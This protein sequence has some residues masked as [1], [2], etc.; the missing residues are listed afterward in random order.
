MRS[1][2]TY[3][4]G[5]STQEFT[6]FDTPIGRCGIVWGEHGIVGVFLPEPDDARTR[7]RL[8]RHFPDAVE[9]RPSA[10]LQTAIQQIT[11]L[12]SG[13]PQDLADV[14]LD[15]E[16]I[17]PFRQEV[18][19]IAR[20]IPPGETLTYGAIAE[21]LGDKLLARDVG[22]AM[23]KNPFPIVVPCHRVVAANGKLGGFSAPG[24][25]NTKLKMLAIEG[26]AVGGQP[27]L[28][29]APGLR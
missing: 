25:A 26:A 22:E 14:P 15:M 17:E 21:K 23:G 28:F 5:M 4:A 20:K 7:K 29:D 27:G 9:A 24:G 10:K 12:L 6:L 19:A 18:Y 1:G 13:E 2:N 8:A 16:R 3:I 11:A